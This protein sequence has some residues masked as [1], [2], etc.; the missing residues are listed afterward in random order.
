[1]VRTTTESKAVVEEARR[2]GYNEKTSQVRWLLL[3]VLLL[4]A[5]GAIYF[6]VFDDKP[7][8]RQTPVRVPSARR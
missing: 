1:M 6:G 2:E 5:A 4:G 7:P 8:P 3:V